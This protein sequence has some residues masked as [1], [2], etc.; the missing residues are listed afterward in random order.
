MAASWKPEDVLAE[1]IEFALTK[2]EVGTVVW[3]HELRAILAAVLPEY[4]RMVREQVAREIE[5]AERALSETDP[6]T[7]ESSHRTAAWCGGL[8]NA[9]RIARGES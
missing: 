4:E 3:P 7:A 5:A 1:L 2:E 6:A 9:T 8:L